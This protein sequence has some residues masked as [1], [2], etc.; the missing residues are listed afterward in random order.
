MYMMHVHT[1]CTYSFR[2]WSPVPE[3]MHCILFLYDCD[4]DR[5]P[6]T[7]DVHAMELLQPY[8]N[9]VILLQGALVNEEA[10]GTNSGPTLQ[11]AFKGTG[12]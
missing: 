3:T 11:S 9:S 10:T 1:C 7:R 8:G 4:Y 5:P 2:T 6:K 12:S